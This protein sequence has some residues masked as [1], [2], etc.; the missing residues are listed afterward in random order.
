MSPTDRPKIKLPRRFCWLPTTTTA[1]T[2][3]RLFEPRKAK[4]KLAASKGGKKEEEKR[5]QRPFSRQKVEKNGRMLGKCCV[6]DGATNKSVGRQQQNIWRT[7]RRPRK[8]FP[9]FST[10]FFS[11]RI[12]VCSVATS[13]AEQKMLFHPGGGKSLHALFLSSFSCQPFSAP[14][15]STLCQLKQA[16]GT[17]NGSSSPRPYTGHMLHLC[18]PE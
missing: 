16:T 5:Q 18:Q 15:P 13:A 14:I 9:I 3:R 6:V 1:T 11:Q 17:N 8:C 10:F 12:G 4:R 7:G 2:R